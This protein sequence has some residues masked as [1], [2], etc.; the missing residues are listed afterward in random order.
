MQVI[1]IL[2]SVCSLQRSVHPILT[3]TVLK[4]FNLLPA[5]SSNQTN[6]TVTV[7]TGSV[8]V[9]VV[10]MIALPWLLLMIVTLS[11]MLYIM[12]KRRE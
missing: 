9:W 3:T 8:P 1:T 10:P 4:L 12:G 6:N 11:V 7:D 5:E 2:W